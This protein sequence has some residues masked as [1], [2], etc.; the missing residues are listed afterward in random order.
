VARSGVV[1][2][3]PKTGEKKELVPDQFRKLGSGYVADLPDGTVYINTPSGFSAI[4]EGGE[5]LQCPVPHRP[6][7][8]D[9][10]HL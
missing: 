7:E 10:P 5:I 4:C 9:R 3:N 2:Y 1:A 8:A 6:K